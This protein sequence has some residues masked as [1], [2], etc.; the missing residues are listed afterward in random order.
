MAGSTFNLDLLV[1]WAQKILVLRCNLTNFTTTE[2]VKDETKDVLR[3][4]IIVTSSRVKLH[5][6][7]LIRVDGQ[8]SLKSLS[9]DETLLKMGI[10]LEVG[11][12]KC[13]NRNSPAER[14][15]QDLRK[16][17]LKLNPR[18]GPITPSSLALATANTNNIQRASRF[19][20]LEMR[21]T[22]AQHQ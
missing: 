12:A 15:I 1:D 17:I 7:M 9:K 6:A 20:A 2:F 4:A 22:R 19:T 8:S 14:T 10:T 3:E 21:T 11:N 16:E 13:K 18:G 5:S